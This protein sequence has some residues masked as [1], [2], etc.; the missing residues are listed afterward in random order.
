MGHPVHRERPFNDIQNKDSTFVTFAQIRVEWIESLTFT[1]F[2]TGC[3]GDGKIMGVHE[4]ETK[5]NSVDTSVKCKVG[6]NY[7]CTI[8]KYSIRPSA[9][10]LLPVHLGLGT[11][12]HWDKNWTKMEYLCGRGRIIFA[13]YLQKTQLFMLKSQ[14]FGSLAP[15]LVSVILTL[16]SIHQV[17]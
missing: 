14:A 17:T 10:P 13:D 11:K 16:V 4:A 5:G 12:V 7:F 2:D 8:L 1:L 6:Q 9:Q 15:G 3:G